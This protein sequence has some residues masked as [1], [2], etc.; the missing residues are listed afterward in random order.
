MNTNTEWSRTQ[1]NLLLQC[2][3]AW[4]MQYG[5]TNK[6]SSNHR[7]LTSQ[8]P[9]NLM[10]RA[11]KETLMDQLE[12]LHQGKEWSQLLTKHQLYSNLKRRTNISMY[13][14]SNVRLESLL[15]FA[16]NRYSRLWRTRILRQLCKNTHSQWYLFDRLEPVDIQGNQLFIAPDMVVRIQNKWHLFRFDMQSSAHSI[17]HEEEANA[18][19]IWAIQHNEFPQ[20]PISFKLHTIAW[21]QGYW[22]QKTYQPSEKSVSNCSILLSNDMNAMK[23]IRT[24]G[25]RNPALLP[26]AQHYRT[27]Q[28]CAFRTFCPGGKD[29]AQ[30]KKEQAL[31]ELSTKKRLLEA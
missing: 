17:C 19:A 27:C 20:N 30:A 4:Y 11:M 1:K 22:H 24:A 7:S 16:Q 23:S 3:R 25:N 8:R 2:P 13:D 10:L 6:Q 14:V 15:K 12:D 31:L 26:L 28:S 21:H 9:W 5:K 18:M 29:L